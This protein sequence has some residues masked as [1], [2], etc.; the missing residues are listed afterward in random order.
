MVAAPVVV[1]IAVVIIVVAASVIVPISVIVVVVAASVVVPISVVD[2]VVAASVIVPIS[3]VIVVVA[4]SVIVPISVVI[5]VTSVVVAPGIVMLR[6]PE[7]ASGAVPPGVPVSVAM[8]VH[9]VPIAVVGGGIRLPVAVSEVD[10]TGW[11]IAV[12]AV[13]VIAGIHVGIAVAVQ[14]LCRSHD[15]CGVK[16]G[17]WLCAAVEL[18]SSVVM[19]VIETEIVHSRIDGGADE[20]LGAFRIRC[21]DAQDMAVR[22]DAVNPDGIHG[23]CVLLYI[24]NI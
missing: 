10:G 11:I 18:D 7:T 24:I 23:H 19:L 13:G 16:I 22:G 4:A 20:G 5:V 15:V 6:I 8:V 12:I 17:Q 1:P 2:V 21:D 9:R 14:V 3:V